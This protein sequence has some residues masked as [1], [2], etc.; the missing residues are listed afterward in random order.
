MTLQDHPP[1][2]LPRSS[3]RPSSTTN[4]DE[5][6]IKSGYDLR[7]GLKKKLSDFSQL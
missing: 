2:A 4:G 7:A 3:T 1:L 6:V 5:A